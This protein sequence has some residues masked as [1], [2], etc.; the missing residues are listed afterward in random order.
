MRLYSEMRDPT[1]NRVMVR[2]PVGYQPES[3]KPAAAKPPVSLL[4]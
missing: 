3:E 1:T 2:L 4:A